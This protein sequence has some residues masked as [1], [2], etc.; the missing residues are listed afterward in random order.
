[1]LSI[2]KAVIENVR[3]LDARSQ[4]HIAHPFD[5]VSP[6]RSARDSSTRNSASVTLVPT[7]LLRT[8]RFI[9]HPWHWS[10]TAQ[11]P[12]RP[13]GTPCGLG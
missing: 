7:D 10:C 1:M 9:A 2:H 3:R 4:Q 11:T 6:A 8:S 5:S 13:H 12:K